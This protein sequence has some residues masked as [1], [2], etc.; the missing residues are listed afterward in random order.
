MRH[1]SLSLLLLA[2]GS[3]ACRTAVPEGRYRCDTRDDCPATWSCHS[4]GFCWSTAE[5]SDAGNIGDASEDA[6]TDA[7]VDA[8]VD[9]QAPDAWTQDAYT[10]VT[11]TCNGRDDDCDGFVDEG[12]ITVGAAVDAVTDAP[13]N[14]LGALLAPIDHGFE[15][16]VSGATDVNGGWAALHPDG[17]SASSFAMAPSALL[18]TGI[19]T[20][21]TETIFSSAGDVSEILTVSSGAPPAPRLRYVFDYGPST[22]SVV[23][24]VDSDGVRATAFAAI[25][26]IENTL[27]VSLH[28]LR[29]N[30]TTSGGVLLHDDPLV[31]TATAVY[32]FVHT[33]EADYLAY[34]ATNGDLV[35]A[36]APSDDSGG[37]FRTIGTILDSRRATTDMALA[38]RNPGASVGPDNP[39]ILAWAD[40]DSASFTQV[41]RTTVLDVD[42]VQSLPGAQGTG[43][44]FFFPIHEIDILPVEESPI[45]GHWIIAATSIA[46][47]DVG[48]AVSRV[49]EISHG[50]AREIAV[51]DESPIYRAQLGLARVDGVMRLAEVGNAGGIVTRS[52]GCE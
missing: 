34:I 27:P 36:A 26:D 1:H 14:V 2:L 30:I 5:A 9:A 22:V 47:M 3:M 45:A 16:I 18:A 43:P 12:L 32:A 52:I 13:P 40:P 7:G 35:L 39:L 38:I 11:E 10:C 48:M 19:A 42:P 44:A 8:P 49:W 50:A 23:R 20:T 28:R 51:P 21:P 17:S 15:V 31:D 29:L 4:D 37:V 46:S 24:I 33:A 41:T 6:S 25:G